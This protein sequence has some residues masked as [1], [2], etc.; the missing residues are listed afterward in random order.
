M[1]R[2]REGR[3][4]PVIL[5]TK[6]A[7]GWLERLCAA[8][9]AAPRVGW[10]AEWSAARRATSARVA[11]QGNLDRGS[12]FSRPEA[13][14]TEVGRVLESYGRGRG[15]VCKLGHGIEPGVGP[16]SGTAMVA[17]VQEMSPAYHR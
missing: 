5:L 1:I 16:E 8:G 12:L 3:H 9:A 7:G 15:H 2:E 4:V 6:G 13:R 11:R 14:R 10:T 17:A